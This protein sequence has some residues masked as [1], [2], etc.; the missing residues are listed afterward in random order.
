M[1]GHLPQLCLFLCLIGPSQ[2]PGAAGERPPTSQPDEGQA[3][4]VPIYVFLNGPDDINKLLDTLSKPDFVLVEWDRFRRFMNEAE[5]P[6]PARIPTSVFRS[7]AITGRIGSDHARL[8]LNLA[9]ATREAGL[10]VVDLPL[11]DNLTIVE[12]RDGTSPITLEKRATG[13]WRLE[14]SGARVHDLEIELLCALKVRG[15]RNLL[16]LGIP[17]TPSN[18]FELLGA[19]G[20]TDIRLGGDTG[21]ELPPK[22]AEDGIRVAS[23]FSPRSG[24]DISWS[25]T[26]AGMQA[27]PAVLTA[28]GEIDVE[29]GPGQV[30]A[31]ATYDLRVLDGRLDFLTV[32]AGTEWKQLDFEIDGLRVPAI[33]SGADESTAWHKLAA[34]LTIDRPQKLV[35]RAVR[36]WVDGK[37]SRLTLRGFPIREAQAQSG[38]LAISR[39]TDVGVLAG[40]L[41]GLRPLDHRTELPASLRVRPTL[42]MGY[43]FSEQPFALELNAVP[44]V[45]WQRVDSRSTVLVDDSLRIE[46]SLGYHV[47]PGRFTRVIVELPDSLVLDQVGPAEV[48]SS[49]DVTE[50]S[51]TAPR[52]MIVELSAKAAAEGRFSIQLRTHIALDR[53]DSVALDLPVPADAIERVEWL[54]LASAD[55]VET[56]VASKEGL[57]VADPLLATRPDWPSEGQTILRGR[58]FECYR[59][60]SPASAVR[61]NLAR[62]DRTVS[63]ES[64]VVAA[65]GRRGARFE[66]STVL[67]VRF[68]ALSQIDVVVPSEFEPGDW[69]V[70]GLDIGRREELAP[71]GDGAARARLFLARPLVGRAPFSIKAVKTWPESEPPALLDLP[72]FQFEGTTHGPLTVEVRSEPGVSLDFPDSEWRPGRLPA[73]LDT[74]AS[75]S[76]DPSFERAFHRRVEEGQDARLSVGLQ[77]RPLAPV[78]GT[79][80]SRGLI[81]STLAASDTANVNTTLVIERHSGSILV[82]LPRGAGNLKAVVGGTALEVERLPAAG[83]FRILIPP[84]GPMPT[85]LDFQYV[86]AHASGAEAWVPRFPAQVEVGELYWRIDAPAFETLLG[87][88]EGWDDRNAWVGWWL[89]RWRRQSQV[90]LAGLERWVADRVSKTST[91]NA[92]PGADA[93]GVERE[94]Y[95]FS[96]TG[97]AA[98]ARPHFMPRTWLIAAASAAGLFG[99]V[100]CARLR[101]LA[102]RWVLLALVAAGVAVVAQYPILGYQ[103]GLAALPGLLVGAVAVATQAVIARTRHTHEPVLDR[104]SS[105]GSNRSGL[106][107]ETA[108]PAEPEEGSTIVRPRAASTVERPTPGTESHRSSKPSNPTSE[109]ISSIH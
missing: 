22:P 30:S 88:P 49:V 39:S 40:T 87:V 68:G 92:G 37:E 26:T 54:A 80:V 50:K 1:V 12:V 108:I 43:Q 27:L 78:A 59:L 17:E 45:A 33:V 34:N 77:I 10:S 100:L 95:L 66:Q 63:T 71:L 57:E 91:A 96:T 15:R 98:G 31:V 99:V 82:Q 103:F 75:G 65:I 74:V 105:V 67:D 94:G 93:P 89:L 64:T 6:K 61:L 51:A 48:V 3:K 79:I 21:Q 19:A 18:R 29:F 16:E 5:Q 42:L 73:T 23:E 97:R 56:R 70:D 35:V 85:R 9:V 14:L 36:G 53:A 52:R 101:L 83:E 47:A 13:G 69:R 41:S 11:G 86:V 24:L 107:P 32:Q 28:L 90:D 72:H 84:A 38:L 106:R 2:D 55:G 109:S 46:T 7:L 104:T 76:I 58:P 4:R 81:H 62:R 25:G 60:L 20:L 44:L 8:R 102:R